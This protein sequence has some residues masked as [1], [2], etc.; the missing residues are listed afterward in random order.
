MEIRVDYS[1]T[2]NMG[3]GTFESCKISAGL[4]KTVPDDKDPYQEIEDEY[5]HLADF[6]MNKVNE[7]GE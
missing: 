2:K 1:Y 6:V 7:I 5:Y 3:K 4:S